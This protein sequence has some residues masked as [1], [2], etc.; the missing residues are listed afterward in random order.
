MTS[1]FLRGP[2]SKRI[3]KDVMIHI[4]PFN[5]TKNSQFFQ[6]GE[7]LKIDRLCLFRV[8]RIL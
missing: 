1:P 5:N 4:N 3:I 7:W 2:L 6:F 8:Y